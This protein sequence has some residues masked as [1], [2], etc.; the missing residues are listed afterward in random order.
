VTIISSPA[1]V[2]DAPPVFA[3]LAGGRT[4]SKGAV[5]EVPVEGREFIQRPGASAFLPAAWI[6]TPPHAD[7]LSGTDVV[8]QTGV[9]LR[10]ALGDGTLF[11]GL[12][13]PLIGQE[14]QDG[15]SAVIF[16]NAR[17]GG[18]ALWITKERVQ[19][20]GTSGSCQGQARSEEPPKLLH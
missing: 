13:G 19:I 5:K 12:N 17:L 4:L 3:L 2:V 16:L 18:R 20:V 15:W 6:I 9:A 7:Q 10:F 8:L 1:V 11:A 14:G